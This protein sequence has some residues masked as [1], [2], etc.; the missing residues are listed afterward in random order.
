MTK[1]VVNPGASIR[2]DMIDL[3]NL[4]ERGDIV[5]IVAHFEGVTATGIGKATQGGRSGDVIMIKN[6]DSG[7]KVTGIIKDSN[8]V[9]VNP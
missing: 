5:N 9:L 8:T 6:V 4:I 3:P 2:T 1:R 7:R